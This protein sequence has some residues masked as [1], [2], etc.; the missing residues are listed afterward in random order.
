MFNALYRLRGFLKRYKKN[1]LLA[2][3]FLLIS[4]F[5][6]FTKPYL[7]G[8]VAD[9]IVASSYTK[10]DLLLWLGVFAFLVFSNYF[11]NVGWSFNLFKNVYL[12]SRDTRYDLMK[13]YLAQF[14]RFFEKNST[15]S[16]MGKATNDIESL[17]EVV[18]YGIMC[19]FDAILY[20]MALMFFMARISWQLTL[21]CALLFGPFIYILFKIDLTLENK[22]TKLQESF[23][24]MNEV[25]L[26]SMSSI[27]V[28][29]AF[30]VEDVFMKKFSKEI[31][32]NKDKDM[33][34]NKVLQLYMPLANA[35]NTILMTA[36]ILGGIVLIKR[37]TMT[38][39][40]LIT[41]T[42]FVSNLS[43][44]AFA[45]S[46]F[47]SLGQEGK[48]SI[49]RIEEILHYKEDIEDQEDSLNL[50][51]AD[52][53]SFKDLDFKYPSSDRLVLE[54]INLNFSKGDTLIVV[55]KTGSG[56][57][58]LLKQF[59]RLYD[60]DKGDLLIND[61]PIEGYK[62]TSLIDKIAYVPQENYLFSR[63]IKDNIVLFRD[64]TD[65][66]VDQ[67][68]GLADLKKDLNKFPKGLD[69]LTGEK[70]VA[71]SGGQRQRIALA[72][73]LIKDSEI[74]ILDDV[75]SAVDTRTEEN[76]I[77]NLVATRTGKTNIFATHR[78]SVIKAEDYVVVL[79]DGKIQAQGS[80]KEVYE[81]SPWYKE[82][83]DIQMMEVDHGQA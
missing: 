20:P 36:S 13:K 11:I 23:D 30:N 78:L 7:I 51:S 75:F 19:I 34:K 38:I 33:D 59:L 8:N 80:H 72:R 77:A 81:K 37:G 39:G 62:R 45:L 66:Q 74:L 16:L 42:M 18:G 60:I 82:Q 53:F 65:S 31:Y 15:G 67:A 26:E 55:G 4:Y 14:P 41:F 10:E 70:G 83:Y 24:Q 27:K 73:A 43:W 17:A 48:A 32:N 79:E 22:F 25:S 46:D 58:T 54:N 12:I 29:R 6:T 9:A 5:V 64:F 68:V 56:K 71:L 35:F 1:Q 52:S 50:K 63:S 69:T 76:I 28:I 44:P 21:F 57:T 3:F 61:L 47:L 2:V 40:S 49:N